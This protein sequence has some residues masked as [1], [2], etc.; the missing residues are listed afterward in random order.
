MRKD[1]ELKRSEEFRERLNDLMSENTDTK[2]N[3][4]KSMG[5]DFRSLSNAYNYGII[6]RAATLI[7]IADFFNV[8]LDYL[9]GRDN[10]KF[11]KSSEKVSFIERYSHLKNKRK[12]NDNEIACNLHFDRTLCYKWK[13]KG[14]IPTLE[15]LDM[16]CDYFDVSPDYLL[17]RTDIEKYN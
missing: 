3:I 9:L 1:G 12:K 15:I 17:G 4:A 16:L 8:S 2:L 6:P 10:D 14:H 13:S 11:I 5:V 7:K